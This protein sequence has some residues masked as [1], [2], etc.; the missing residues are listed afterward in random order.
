MPD[1]FQIGDRRIG[2][3]APALIVAEVAQAHDGSLGAA[4]AFIDAVA[5][6]GAEAVK[7]QV[8]IAAEE[9]TPGEPWRVRFS[10]QDATRYEYWKRMEFSAPQWL[11]LADHA[12]ERGLLFLVSP[13]SVAAVEMM[14]R[15]GVPAWKIGA[16]EVA[17][18]DL[19]EAVLQ[20]RKPVLLSSGMSPWAELDAAVERI[21]AKDIPFAVYQCTTA[22]PCPPERIGFNVLAELRQRYECPVGLSDHSG[23][24]AAGLA[25]CALG[26][27]LVEVHVTFSRQAFGPDVPASLTFEDLRVLVDGARFIGRALGAPVDKDAEAAALGDMR[28]VF[29]KRVVARTDLPAGHRIAPGDVAFK[30]AA[31]GAPADR[32]AAVA[33]RVLRRAVRADEGIGDNDV[34]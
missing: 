21:R 19:A 31:A 33:G 15:I 27:D 28:T 5:E 10:R 18:P 16:G 34:E 24:A 3:G 29:R 7:F 17:T 12:R 30:K 8:H 20:T 13:F 26:A 25:A 11:E 22:Y 1:S 4:H 6:S 32:A 23:V 14:E 2:A 9:S